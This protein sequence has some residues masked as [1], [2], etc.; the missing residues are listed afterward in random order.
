MAMPE[1]ACSPPKSVYDEAVPLLAA[2]IPL[3]NHEKYIGIALD[4]VYAQTL[5][6]NRVIVIDDGSTDESFA[7]AKSAA[8][9]GTEVIHQKNCGADATLNHAI[10]M[11][12]DCEFVAVLN[13]DDVWHP[14]RLKR[15]VE[16]MRHEPNAEVVCTGLH[17]IDADGRP[18]PVD[19][20]KMKR[21][22]K[23]WDLVMTE[24][25]PLLSLAVSNFAKTTSNIAA[26]TAF[27]LS[28]PFREYR[29][30]HDYRFFLKAALFNRVTVLSDDLLGYR[31]H[32]T[33]T[34]KVDGRRAVVAETV[35]MHVDL[36]G[37]LALEFAACAT[38]R[39]RWRHYLQ[40]LLGNY[41]DFSGEL[42]LQVIAQAIAI[43]PTGF[44]VAA[45][46]DLEE[47]ESKSSPLPQ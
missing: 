17:L 26:R 18:L 27:L 23:V 15:C 6:P 28:H 32:A 30:V 43:A 8:R 4:S 40:R 41:T 14:D 19:H 31:T 12:A 35:Q 46:G 2:V 10:S 45:L 22:T 33:N 25:D 24:N 7:V 44:N 37:H 21:H 36:L 5:Q 16:K 34:I 47:F 20:P 29:Y 11:A 3:F 9:T 1:R 38:L 13:S 39:K 42:F